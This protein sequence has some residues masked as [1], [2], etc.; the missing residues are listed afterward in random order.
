[1]DASSRFDQQSYKID[2]S[3][4][5]DHICLLG[6]KATNQTNKQT[7]FISNNVFMCVISW[8]FNETLF[9]HSTT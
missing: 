2:A 8:Y 3:S 1:M 6:I 4:R 9:V 7:L 5:F